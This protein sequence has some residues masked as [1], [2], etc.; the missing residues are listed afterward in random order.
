MPILASSDAVGNVE[1]VQKKAQKK[2]P[3]NFWIW[4]GSPPPFW[5]MSKR[6]Q[7]L[8]KD[9]FPMPGL[10]HSK[11]KLLKNCMI[12][13]KLLNLASGWSLHMVLNVAKGYSAG[14]RVITKMHLF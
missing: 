5:T 7:L 3:Q 9:Y 13:S 11:S 10:G 6:K 14:G 4:V 12:V 2:L 1:K 8:F